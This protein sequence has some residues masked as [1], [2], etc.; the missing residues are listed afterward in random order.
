MLIVMQN[1]ATPDQIDAVCRRVRELGF[2]PNRIPGSTRVAI[3]ITGNQTALDPDLF[4]DCQGVAQ[5]LPVSRPYKLVSR[6]VKREDT[7]VEVAGHPVGATQLTVIA[8]PCSVESRDQLLAAAHAAKAAGAH[9]LRGGA[10]K[11]RTNPYA[12]QG[13]AEEGLQLLAEARDLTG[14]PIVTEVKDSET[15]PLVAR[16]ADCLQIG[17]RNMQN[18]SLL[19]AVGQT[20]KPVLLKKGLASTIDELLQAAEYILSQGNYRVILCE[21]G[22]RTFETAFRNTQDLSA[23]VA[24]KRLSHLPVIVDP[25]HATGHN[26]AVAPLARAAV[27]VGADGLMIEIHP[28]PAHALCDGPQALNLPDFQRL[29][30]QLR[31]LAALMHRTL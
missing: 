27:A 29:M 17:A 12:F 21:R 31:P 5:C 25:S 11:P 20:G 7:V 18:S 23:V 24:V 26:W 10:F 15:L 22:I 2:T 6:E 3:G 8:G 19:Q 30:D 14:L 28:D 1:N 13:L 16:Y 4:A 9:L